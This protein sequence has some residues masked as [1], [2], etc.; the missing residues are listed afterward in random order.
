LGQ[1]CGLLINKV[2]SIN[3]R[4]RIKKDLRAKL[5]N[6]EIFE[7]LLWVTK[8]SYGIRDAAMIDVLNAYK[9]N[10]SKKDNSKL[11]QEKEGTQ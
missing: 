11:I 7:I 6:N 4:T 3:K 8:G 9:S 5:I 2:F 10:F 1:Q